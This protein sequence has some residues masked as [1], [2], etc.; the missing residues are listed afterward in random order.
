[1]KPGKD[2]TL[3]ESYRPI[4][5][6]GCDRK[7]M[8]KM[9]C[10]RFD[11]WAEQN[12]A[13]SPTQYGFRKGKGTR[14]CLAIL[15]TDIK[16]SFE[17]KNQTVAAFLDISGAYD[18]VL[19]DILCKIMLEKKWPAKIVRLLW[20]LLWKKELHFYVGNEKHIT[21]TGY[22]GLPQ[23]SVLSPFLYNLIGSDIDRFIPLG[24][25]ILQYADD[26]VIYATHRLMEIAR[27][28]VQTACTALSVFFDI[29]GL[30]I[31]STKSETMVFSRK[32]TKPELRI[33]VYGQHLPQTKEFKYLGVFFDCGLRWSTQVHYVQRRCLQRLNFMNSIAGTWWGAHPKCMLLLYQGLIGSVLEYASICYANMAKTHF[34][35]LERIQYRGI[36]IA[37]GLMKSTPNNSLGVLSGKPPLE[38]RFT[39]LNSKFLLKIFGK[40]DHP[41]Q[42]TILDLK[43]LNPDRCMKGTNLIDYLEVTAT[44]EY[45]QFDLAALVSQPKIDFSIFN[46]LQEV[47]EDFYPIIAPRE[48]TAIT[49]N[50]PLTH[51][52]YTDGSM[53][54]DQTGF[55]IHNNS[56]CKLEQRLQSPSSVFSAEILAIKSALEYIT[57][58]PQ[59]KYIIFSDSMSSLMALESRKFSCQSHPI[60]LHCKQIYY[61]IQRSGH[62]VTLSWVPAHV[63][64]PGNEIADEMAKNAC[65]NGTMSH[66]PPLPPDFKKLSKHQMLQKWK[67]KWKNCDTGRL[68]HSI[69]PEVTVK[70]WFHEFQEERG[71][72]TT[73]SRIITGHCSAKSHLNRFNIVDDPLC[74]CRENYETVDHLMW[75]CPR[76]D[77]QSVI[78]ELSSLGIQFGTP[79]RDLCAL[80]KYEALKVCHS[81]FKNCGVQ[82]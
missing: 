47:T 9:L 19:I 50:Y 64:V 5:L 60:V 75:E 76:F 35:K 62:D 26:V 11:F 28:L 1:L 22:K 32:H 14:D 31:S 72:I 12:G 6:L 16:T 8:E 4:S 33:L 45:Y 17:M 74:V 66:Q 44:M 58:K 42:K 79:I 48:V 3:A 46:K 57:T 15:T 80:K 59:G 61:D 27:Y 53:I 7:I 20:N 38:E 23:G 10:V 52:I 73:I 21:R 63:G 55:A 68:T 37:L 36:R 40:I 13:L 2:P 43:S 67:T 82:I 25:K 56:D 49:T 78:P 24:C 71:V 51:V 39:Y 69:F 65:T 29:I 54:R 34:L 30:T 70:P 18:N 77:R 81:F 41:L